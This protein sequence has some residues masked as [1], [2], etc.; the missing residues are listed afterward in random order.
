MTLLLARTAETGEGSRGLSLFFAEIR[1]EH[2][3]LNGIEV[4]RLKDK[5]GTEA[6]P[7]AEL[8]LRGMQAEPVGDLGQGVKKV[9]TMLNITRLYNSVCAVS[10]MRRALDW[11]V[12]YSQV[13]SAFGKKIMEQPL[14]RHTLQTL[15]S[16]FRDCFLL[17]F[18]T[19]RLLGLEETGQAQETQ[20]RW[21]R[22]LTPVVKLYTAKKCLE[23]ASECLEGF[24][25]AGY[26]ENLP[27]A[28][29][30]RDAQV[31]SIWEGTTNVL[32]LDFLRAFEK[33]EGA[34]LLQD[35]SFLSL[36]EA[37]TGAFLAK[38]KA[39]RSVEEIEARGR[40]LAFHFAQ[41][42]IEAARKKP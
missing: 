8:S 2:G 29:L 14:F 35:K 18:E 4:K 37:G 15:E 5:L 38:V 25:G 6:L 36:S 41:L 33:E 3:R 24:G 26:I 16:T 11:L 28:R 40:D 7:T 20:K 31:F 10:H 42:V 23:V 9:S 13:R 1:D 27:L 39:C 21:L 34:A 32:S 19:G 30:L 12:A 17:T 22:L